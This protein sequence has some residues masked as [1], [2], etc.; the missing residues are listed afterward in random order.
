VGV[1]SERVAAADSYAD[2]RALAKAAKD[3]LAT[4]KGQ[5]PEIVEGRAEVAG[6][7]GQAE[8][9]RPRRAGGASGIKLHWELPPRVAGDDGRDSV[10]YDSGHSRLRGAWLRAHSFHSPSRRDRLWIKCYSST[11]SSA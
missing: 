3:E 4:L 1:V 10:P 9:R 11:P 8:R 5:K 2:R 6:D 7:S